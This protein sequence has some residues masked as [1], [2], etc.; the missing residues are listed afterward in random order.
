MLGLFAKFG[1]GL[2]E[3]VVQLTNV[4]PEAVEGVEGASNGIRSVD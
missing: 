4:G 3:V 2:T 1:G